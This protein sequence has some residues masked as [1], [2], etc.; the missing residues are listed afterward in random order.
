MERVCNFERSPTSDGRGPDNRESVILQSVKDV[1][2][3]TSVGRDPEML[4]TATSISVK[5]ESFPISVGIDPDIN[6]RVSVGKLLSF[7]LGTA[8]KVSSVNC[9]RFPISVGIDPNMKG[10]TIR[11]D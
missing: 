5:Y 2:C 4:D 7:H 1:R 11:R 10:D 3:P 6:G 8:P 9:E